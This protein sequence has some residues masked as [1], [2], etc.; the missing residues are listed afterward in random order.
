MKTITVLLTIIAAVMIIGC[1]KD[2]P[3][4]ETV[5]ETVYTD[6]LFMSGQSY[7]FIAGEGDTLVT[8]EYL[9]LAS[10]DDGGW[11]LVFIGGDIEVTISPVG[12]LP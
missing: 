7:V 10:R 6:T 9:C 2:N 11:M 12:E 4:I 3:M 8:A 5:N 1:G